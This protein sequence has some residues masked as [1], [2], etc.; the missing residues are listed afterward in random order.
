MLCCD[1][2]HEP[3]SKKYPYAT[4]VCTMMVSVDKVEEDGASFPRCKEKLDVCCNCAHRLVDKINE[5][6]F[7]FTHNVNYLG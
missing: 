4:Q 6:V 2:C 3:V 7:N 1:V 5:I